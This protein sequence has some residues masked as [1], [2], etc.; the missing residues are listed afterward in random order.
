[1][2][3]SLASRTS[4]NKKGKEIGEMCFISFEELHRS[5]VVKERNISFR[6]ENFPEAKTF[7]EPVNFSLID[8]I[9]YFHKINISDILSINLI[10]NKIN[11]IDKLDNIINSGNNFQVPEVFINLD[12]CVDNRLR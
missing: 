12:V 6:I 8:R 4:S 3:F 10:I 2:E 7:V 5:S 11:Y 9:F 1:M